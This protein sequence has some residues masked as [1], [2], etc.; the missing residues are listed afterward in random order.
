LEYRLNVNTVV[1]QKALED[2][3][4]PTDT[5][6]SVD[7]NTDVSLKSALASL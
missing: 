3:A 5:L 4:I 7:L 6:I 1:D 2:D